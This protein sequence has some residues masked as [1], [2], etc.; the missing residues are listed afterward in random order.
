MEYP[1]CDWF[2]CLRQNGE[3]VLD[4]NWCHGFEPWSCK[5]TQKEG[6]CRMEHSPKEHAPDKIG[7]TDEGSEGSGSGPKAVNEPES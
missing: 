5:R 2:V 1:E 4:F 6:K 3:K 7:G